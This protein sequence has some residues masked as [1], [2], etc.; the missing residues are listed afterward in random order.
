MIGWLVETLVASTL[1]MGLVLLLRDRTAAAFGARTAYLLWLLPI[2]RMLLPR[3]P[4]FGHAPVTL[5]LALVP[6]DHADFPPSGDVLP[7]GPAAAAMVPP[8]HAIDGVIQYLPLLA[9]MVWLGGA[10]LFFAWQIGLYRHFV[11]AALRGS[12]L[13]CRSCGISVHSGPHIAGPAAVG[14]IRRRILLP[15]DFTTRYAPV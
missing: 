1:L 8:P 10:I 12:A 7:H 6:P 4:G 9:L 5:D 3:L 13:L 14:V 11:R 15:A 2:A